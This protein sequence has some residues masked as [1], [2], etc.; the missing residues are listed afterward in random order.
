VL[1]THTQAG[2]NR[3][4]TVSRDNTNNK[5]ISKGKDTFSHESSTTRIIFIVIVERLSVALLSLSFLFAG[6]PFFLLSQAVCD[7]FG[8][9]IDLRTISHQRTF[10]RKWLIKRPTSTLSFVTS[11][12]NICFQNCR[13]SARPKK[14]I[15]QNKKMAK[16]YSSYLLYSPLQSLPCCAAIW[17][18]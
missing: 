16:C 5:Q 9:I 3:H 12:K 4:N 7:I 15:L 11:A 17:T 18:Y 14:Y 10:L 6:F 13:I 2:A 1:R 8:E